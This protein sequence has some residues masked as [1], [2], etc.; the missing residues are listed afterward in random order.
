VSR[1][2]AGEDA[3]LLLL[4]LLSVLLEFTRGGLLLSS[5]FLC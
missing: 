1:S 5:A 3:A 2:G 4:L